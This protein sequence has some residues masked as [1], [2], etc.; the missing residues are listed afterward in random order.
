LTSKY[1]SKRHARIFFKGNDYY[2]VDLDSAN[3]AYVNGK[4]VR[5]RVKLADGDEIRLGNV[6]IKFALT[7][8]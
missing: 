1:I 5:S 2:I 4:P 6:V 7:N 3:G 8:E